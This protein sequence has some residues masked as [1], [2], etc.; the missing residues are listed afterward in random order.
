MMASCIYAGR[1]GT[2]YTQDASRAICGSG[3]IRWRPPSR[4]SIKFR[5]RKPPP[6][7]RW[8]EP[9]L[10]IESHFR[11]W[12]TD[13]LVRQAAFKG[14][15]EDKPPQEVVRE[16]PAMTDA[17]QSASRKTAPKAAAETAK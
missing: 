16:L 9:R 8:V 12:T 11:G 7:R 6:R 14:V 1:I 17:R 4:R 5:A 3:C 13:G 15:R 2:G 10:V